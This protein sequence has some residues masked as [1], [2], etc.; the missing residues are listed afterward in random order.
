MRLV[1][2]VCQLGLVFRAWAQLPEACIT[3]NTNRAPE[4]SDI[5]VICGTQYMDL[6]I[7]ICPVY[8]AMYNESLMVTINKQGTG[9]FADFSS[10]QY[11]NISGFVNS[12]DPSAGMITYSPQILYKFSCLYPMQYLLNNTEI[13]VSGVSLAV[14]DNNGTFSST[15]SMELYQDDQYQQILNIPSTGLML[16]TKIYVAVLA[17]NL[18]DRCTLDAQT[19]VELNGAS[20]RAH[21]SFEAFRFVEHKNQPISTFYL[22]CI[23]RLCEVSSCSSLTPNCQT[24]Q[25]RRKREAENVSTNATVTSHLIIVGKQSTGE[26]SSLEDKKRRHF[27]LI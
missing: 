2:L 23:T 12:I 20:Q 14:R 1:L 13:A 21:F 3:S 15:L 4:N 6:S 26:C 11:V 16:K 27:P 17:T 25:K 19:K 10:V 24:S 18:T 22:H 9:L 8:Y 7:Y 5:S